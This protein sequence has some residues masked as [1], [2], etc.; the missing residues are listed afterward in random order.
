MCLLSHSLLTV[1]PTRVP[2]NLPTPEPIAP[3]ATP[4]LSPTYCL[5]AKF[6]SQ[7]S[8]P[9]GDFLWNN[10]RLISSNCECKVELTDKGN[11]ELS[12]L[13]AGSWTDIWESSTEIFD[14]SGESV[15]KMEWDEVNTVLVINEYLYRGVPSIQPIRLW[16]VNVTATETN[17][18]LV[19]SDDCCLR[20]MDADD[21]TVHWSTCAESDSPI[22]EISEFVVEKTNT[23]VPTESMVVGADAL[24]GINRNTYVPL[25]AVKQPLFLIVISYPVAFSFVCLDTE[26]SVENGAHLWLYILLAVIIMIGMCVAG[27]CWRSHTYA[28]GNWKDPRT[29]PMPKTGAKHGRGASDLAS[30][31]WSQQEGAKADTETMQQIEDW[32]KEVSIEAGGPSPSLIVYERGDMQ[33]I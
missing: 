18:V 23:N 33:S 12:S 20:L 14:Y 1:I 4:T 6:K 3:T 9:K 27:L 30:A 32:M 5:N 10:E 15:S 8:L 31:S 11:L 24:N 26:S 21:F 17:A 22:V 29:A 28:S 19:L 16:S 13:S 2:T 7:M 25:L